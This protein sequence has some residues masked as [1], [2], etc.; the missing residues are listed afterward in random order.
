MISFNI[1][2]FLKVLSPNIVTLGTWVWGLEFYLWIL[3]RAVQSTAHTR[4]LIFP[5]ISFPD[6][7][8]TWLYTSEHSRPSR[9][10]IQVSQNTSAF[11]VQDLGI[12]FT[13]TFTMPGTRWILAYNKTQ[14]G[15]LKGNDHHHKWNS[16]TF[17]TWKCQKW[18]NLTKRS[19]RKTF[20]IISN[21]RTQ[22]MF[23]LV[24]MISAMLSG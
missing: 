8:L 18:R 23:L 1:N 24:S 13:C 4:I 15:S 6:Y 17:C 11:G 7:F 12:P 19:R 9:T 10:H 3:G 14:S 5:Y 21:I 20:L 22:S 16:Q 2:Y